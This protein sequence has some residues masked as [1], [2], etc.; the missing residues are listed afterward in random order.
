[1]IQCQIRP[2][3]ASPEI[4]RQRGRSRMT[5]CGAMLCTD[6]I[7]LC[8]DTLEAVGG[9]HRSV[10]KLVELPIVSDD[11]HAVA[12][13]ATEDGVFSDALLEKI[14]DRL[15]RCDGTFA[16]A[17]TAIED[18]T[19][20]YC[21]AIWRVLDSSQT[22]PTA[23]ILIGL[24]TV[25][26]LRL[27]Q[28]STPTVRAIE[29]WEFIGYGAELGIY[30]AGQYGLRNMPTDTAAPIITYIVDVVKNNSNFC[31]RPTSLAILHRNGNVEHK[32]QDY[33]AKTTQGYKSLG[34]LLDTW[35]F[36][37]LPLIVSDAGEDVLSMI[38]KLG[39][40][41]AEWVEK[42]PKILEFLAVRKKAILTGEI[43]AIPEGHQ[44]KVAVNGLSLAARMIV[45]SSKQLYE[46]NFLSEQSNN[47]IQA[48][49]NKVVELADLVKAGMA[50]PE[51]DRET[52][53]QSLDRL[54]L[55]LTSFQSTKQLMLGTSEDQPSPCD[56]EYPQTDQNA[57]GD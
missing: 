6:G 24:K 2:Q 30:K 5:I 31:G 14:S 26:D 13:S 54:C 39:E 33:I 35:I 12:V 25:D 29:G 4:V 3:I 53:K 50:N 21:A 38:G 20:E 18:A 44:R 40:P 47:T 43:R 8:A 42:I 27:L 19:L 46:E 28:V 55:L 23:Q 36:P 34:W 22:K 52:I 1:M 48:R 9:V 57:H 37:F 7:V 56:E 16:S 32:G 45:N 41:K 15:N 11:L 49:Y 17:K 51:I 10:E